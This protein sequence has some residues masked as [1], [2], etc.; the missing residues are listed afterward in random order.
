MTN[1]ILVITQAIISIALIVVA[2]LIINESKK[3]NK[4]PTQV[5]YHEL[6]IKAE[7]IKPVE[8]ISK[9]IA[10]AAKKTL[11][12]QD[13]VG[14]VTHKKR[15]TYN[16]HDLVASDKTLKNINT[17]ENM[18]MKATKIAKLL[19]LSATTIYNIKTHNYGRCNKEVA[20]KIQTLVDK[21]TL[22]KKQEL[23]KTS[24]F[25]NEVKKREYQPKGTHKGKKMVSSAKTLKNIKTL[26]DIPVNLSTVERLLGLAE[27]ILSAMKASNNPRCVKTTAD[28]IQQLIN[29]PKELTRL[30]SIY[31]PCGRANVIPAIKTGKNIKILR[32]LGLSIRGITEK[33]GVSEHTIYKINNANHKNCNKVTAD[34]IQALVDEYTHDYT[35]AKK[36]AKRAPIGIKIN[37][38]EKEKAEDTKENIFLLCKNGFSMSG[39]ARWAGVD[40]SE[41]L[42]I[43]QKKELWCKK[44]TAKKIQD[45]VNK[46]TNSRGN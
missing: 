38:K 37:K 42:N 40:Y 16:G 45:I 28:K 33:T 35:P 11:L 10:E 43:A 1:L 8:D 22:P 3:K 5:V 25:Q 30:R 12:F 2:V 32:A 15:E 26:R 13:E 9:D 21:Y 19:G 39:I 23:K 36:T 4:K 18:G 7:P 31:N 24:L 14:H 27:G 17:L 20:D 6:K 41:I 29:N 46:V 34:K 44:V